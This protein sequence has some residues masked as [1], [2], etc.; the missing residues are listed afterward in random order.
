MNSSLEKYLTIWEM[1][2]A[3]DCVPL[4][5]HKIKAKLEAITPQIPGQSILNMLKAE[6]LIR[7]NPH[8]EYILTPKGLKHCPKKIFENHIEETKIPEERKNPEKF[9][10]PEEWIRFRKL[11]PYYMDCI[12]QQ[13]KAQE[14]LFA[15]DEN[16]KFF[17]PASLGFNWLSPLDQKGDDIV[18]TIPSKAFAAFNQILARADEGEEIYI[19]YPLEAFFSKGK[20]C[21][22][23]I[24]LIPVDI[25]DFSRTT[26]TINIRK[27][28][29]ELNQVWLDYQIPKDRK[30]A[31]I[32]AVLMLHQKDEYNG[33]MDLAI[34][35]P[36]IASELKQPNVVFSPSHLEQVLP[37]LSGGQKACNT[38]ALFVGERLRYTKTLKAEL[39]YIA[40]QP[41][42]VFEQT[43]LAYI[44]REHPLP[45]PA[46]DFQEMP[47]PFIDCNQEQREAV[48]YSINQPV[49]KVTGPPGTGKSQVAIN[50]ISNLVYRGKTVLFTSKNHKAVHAIESRS[51]SLLGECGLDLVHFCSNEDS[52][53][54]NPWYSQDIDLLVANASGYLKADEVLHEDF[55]EHACDRWK[56]VENYYSPREIVLKE[57]ASNQTAFEKN[58]QTVLNLL[59]KKENASFTIETQ[60]D[61]LFILKNLKAKPSGKIR[62]VLW[63]FF[64]KKKYDAALLR[65]KECFPELYEKSFGED[66]LKTTLKS[67]LPFVSEN[68]ELYKN[69]TAIAQ[70]TK[71]V[72]SLDKGISQISECMDVF[73]Q[74][75]L[76]AFKFKLG[77]FISEL[78]DDID[79][80]SRLKSVMSMLKKGKDPFFLRRI[81]KEEYQKAEEGFVLFSK[82]FPAWA[83]TLLSLTKAS[84]CIPGLF[85]KVII[86][87]ASQ[88]EIPPIIPALFR[89]KTVT[90]IG[91]PNQFPP[92][93]DLKDQRHTYLQAKYHIDE[94]DDQKFDFKSKSAYDLICQPPIMLREHFRCNS[95]IADYFNAEFYDNRLIVRTDSHRLNFPTCMGYRHAV[96]WH[97]IKNS[98][99]NEISETVSLVSELVKNNYSGSIGVVTPFRNIAETLKQKLYSLSSERED[100]VINTANGFQ[101]DEKDVI[102]FVLGYND[103]LNK[104]QFWYAEARENRYIYNVAVSRAKACLIIVGDKERCAESNISV[105]KSLA[106]LPKPYLPPKH[107]FDSVWEKRFYVALTEA[108]IEAKPQYPLMGRRLDMAI[109][110][111]SIKLDIEVDGVRYH[112]SDTGERKMDDIFRD[113]QIEGAG[114]IVMRF[115][116][117]EIQEDINACIKRIQEKLV[118]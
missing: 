80:I 30:E 36:L 2:S 63:D 116:V 35:L 23:P 85:D 103:S 4:S 45:N 113:L 92:V 72:P 107:L 50:I 99:E 89:A 86:D 77:Y 33:L 95:E 47:L 111:P 48:S 105:L 110:T 108:G 76:P 8:G 79:V 6:G 12:Q 9:V 38:A 75:L 109:I 26:L 41:D 114:W 13:E 83:T 31:L 64:K 32:R 97:N 96:E 118:S 19:G 55:V 74:H 101:G 40:Q 69:Y 81:K 94:L 61:I 88:C 62:G 65:V 10:S 18:I 60:K 68:I 53:K 27:E 37:V 56:T 17:L 71:S 78:A 87:E 5:H 43:A 57:L 54:Q 11:L 115:W 24:G 29:A 73:K 98:M 46:Y 42:S 3:G 22:V 66:D 117:S 25:V 44:F 34:A 14:Y 93:I 70:K 100:L 104:G 82:Y 106:E 52:T 112:T 16:K 58:R 7:A 51:A 84:P 20:T 1:T 67:A 28:E 90:V 49:S 91:D 102:I 59:R 15:S 21:Y 39:N